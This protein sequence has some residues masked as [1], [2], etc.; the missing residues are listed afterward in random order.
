MTVTA[1]VAR[2]GWSSRLARVGTVASPQ[3]PDSDAKYK[4]QSGEPGAPPASRRSGASRASES[5]EQ[6]AFEVA[7][8]GDVQENGVVAG[9]R[10]AID[11]PDADGR[12]GSGPA[13]NILE[14][15]FRDVVGARE[16]QETPARLEHPQRA[17]VDF[18]VA[19]RRRVDRR[20][21]AR[22]WRRVE[23]DHPEARARTLEPA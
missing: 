17:Q 7:G 13:T 15:R 18:L 19:A 10:E 16:R 21:V 8:L 6:E 14:E 23:H 4:Q 3:P 11:N 20:S 5:F 22:E 9:L 2:G 1:R 12:I